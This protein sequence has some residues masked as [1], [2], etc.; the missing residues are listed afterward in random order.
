MR[1]YEL[2]TT[3]KACFLTFSND[4]VEN[5]D[6][7]EN[8]EDTA[9]EQPET[10]QEPGEQDEDTD[11]SDDENTPHEPAEDTTQ[12]PSHTG[13]SDNDY[14]PSTPSRPSKPDVTVEDEPEQEQEPAET[15]Q[16]PEDESAPIRQLVCGE[17]RIDTS[18]TIVL[19]GYG[20][21]LLHEDDPV[22]RA[23]MATIIYRLLD[24]DTITR[25]SKADLTFTDVAPGAWYAP[26][27]SVIQ[28]ARI[29]NGVADGLY[30][31]DGIVTWAQII[32]VLSRFVEPEDYTLQYIQYDGWAQ[33]P[34]QTAVALGWIEDS[35]DFAPDAIISR[36]A[37]VQL[38]NSV[39]ELYRV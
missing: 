6:E 16:P 26:Y 23:Q 37:L 15:E 11:T 32:T 31:P 39:L 8:S 19:L 34:I 5:S 10:P 12:E 17:A 14:T 7:D 20:D 9:P 1:P 36:G 25:Y 13:S 30:D 22:T 35:A 24:D 29:V 38:I 21:G 28:A 18:K 27:V 2:T 33:E 4:P 3:D